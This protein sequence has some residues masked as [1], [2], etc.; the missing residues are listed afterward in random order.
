M[1]IKPL[2]FLLLPLLAL[3]CLVHG[4][5]TYKPSSVLAT[6]NWYQFSVGATG[7]YKLDV[8]FLNSLGLSGTLSSDA[9]RVYGNGGGM[10]PESNAAERPDDLLER[11]IWVNDGGDGQLNGADYIVLYAEGPDQWLKDSANRRFSHQKNLYTDRAYYYITLGGTGKRVPAQVLAPAAATS[12]NSFDDRYFHELDTINLL[13]SGK[14]WLG[15]EFSSAPGRTLKRSFTFAVPD[16]LAGGTATLVTNAVARSIS[17]SSR[18]EASVNGQVVQQLTVPAVSAGAFDLFAQQAQQ[19]SNFSAV[20][21]PEVSFT[22]FPGSFNSQGWMNWFEYF[23]R[24]ALRLPNGGSLLFRDWST[25]G[26]SAVAFELS[27]ADGSTQVWDVT[28]GANPVRMNGT[29]A[30]TLYR[31]SNEALRLREYA[32]FST[33]FLLPKAEGRVANQNLHATTEADLIIITHPPFLAQANR[34]AQFHRDRDKMRVVVATTT[35]VYQEFASGSP[36]PTALRDYVKLY[37]DRYRST[38]PDSGRYLLLVGKASFDYKNRVNGN[39]NFVPSWESPGFIDPLGT[40]PSDD[41][42]GFLDDAD[43]INNGLV[44]NLLDIGIGRIPARS[45]EEVRNYT[46]KLIDYHSG[47]SLGAWRNN[48]NFIADDEDNNLHL[49]DAETLTATAATAAPELNQAKIYLDAFHQESGSAGG[50]YPQV[51]TLVNSNI[52]NGTLLWNYSGHGGAQRLAEEVV[53]DPSIVNNWNNEH[54]LPLFITATC[55]F[56]PYDNPLDHSLGEDLLVRART[57][58]IALMTTTRVV[59]AY[60][61]RILNNN[62]LQ[63]A[64]APDAN[65]RYRS[66]G[67]ASRKAKNYTYQTSGDL[68]NNRKFVLLGDPAMTLGFPKNRLVLTR[69]NGKE[70]AVADTLGATASVTLEGEVQDLSGNF[71]SGF[72]GTASVSVFDKVRNSKTLG[73]D[74]TSQPVEFAEQNSVLF[75]GKATIQNGRYTIRFRMPKDINYQYGNGRI[76]LYGQD[77]GTDGNGLET[78][79]LIGG[80]APTSG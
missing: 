36:D 39:T 31:F 72:N 51:N 55:D 41:Y 11:A 80:F 62:Y 40:Y 38:W 58:A 77:G 5:R 10:L 15:E 47:T 69:V 32:A 9:I 26:T 76:S 33:A 43:D 73:N 67:D 78:R 22:Y 19:A 37:Y 71:L 25:V 4:Q 27:N 65:G 42:F 21:N 28:D 59:F 49:E 3:S 6:G 66:L 53:I 52:L 75:R 7:M 8:A 16:A 44:Q 68:I 74:P 56:A 50:R 64:L 12:Q 30:G 57:G 79:V 45:E 2:R 61:N 34:I 23:C 48:L 60:S 35:Q 14:T 24:S 1:P 70:I 29:L 54:R 46:D 20:A 17:I 18:F 13:N 63:F